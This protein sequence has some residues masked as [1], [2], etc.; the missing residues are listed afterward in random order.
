MRMNRLKLKVTN[1]EQLYDICLK[2]VCLRGQLPQAVLLIGSQM[3]HNPLLT[4]TSH[5]HA[6]T[7]TSESIKATSTTTT[8]APQSTT[9]SP[10][11]IEVFEAKRSK[12]DLE[13]EEKAVKEIKS[14][15]YDFPLAFEW[16]DSQ[17]LQ[18]VENQRIRNQVL[19]PQIIGSEVT[20]ASSSGS[21]SSESAAAVD[22]GE[23]RKRR[24][25]WKT[26]ST[27]EGQ[28]EATTTTTTTFHPLVPSFA[29]LSSLKQ[30]SQSG[31]VSV[32]LPPLIRVS[33]SFP[34]FTNG[35]C[36]K[37]TSPSHCLVLLLFA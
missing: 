11:E 1:T 6:V 15:G 17:D 24:R 30:T 36:N 28:S 16:R 12:N 23:D 31:N 29:F 33:F 9:E 7:T 35:L 19:V 8:T 4:H 32:S 26:G 21:T 22:S 2:D 5:T 27:A 37:T 3:L 18:S 14:N 13:Y 20:S 34:F 25:G 10:E